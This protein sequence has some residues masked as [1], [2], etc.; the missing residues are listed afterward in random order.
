MSKTEAPT[1]CCCPIYR[2][3]EALTKKWT[4]HILRTMSE[5]KQMR[6]TDIKEALPEINSRML[7]E[8]LSDLEEEGML[9]RTV[10]NT[11]PIT[12]EYTITE[13]GKDFETVLDAICSWARKWKDK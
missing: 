2:S 6:F 13:K 11:K 12:I 7:S 9:E 1:A 3:I 4:I 10:Q 8:R 5:H